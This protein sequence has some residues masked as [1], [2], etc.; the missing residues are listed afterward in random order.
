M[1]LIQDIA[2]DLSFIADPEKRQ[3][4]GDRLATEVGRRQAAMGKACFQLLGND[5]PPN[6]LP[7]HGNKIIDAWRTREPWRSFN[8][9]RLEGFTDWDRENQVSSKKEEEERSSRSERLSS[10]LDNLLS[11]LSFSARESLQLSLPSNITLEISHEHDPDKQM[12]VERRSVTIQDRKQPR[13]LS[14]A[15]HRFFELFVRDHFNA[16]L[17]AGSLARLAEKCDRRGGE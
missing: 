13:A 2:T 12:E 1:A 9:K 10:W 16:T 4:E 17:A 5:S 7:I 3:A 11:D 6:G 14:R 15:L 8:E